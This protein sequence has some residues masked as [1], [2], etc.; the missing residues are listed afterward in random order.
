MEKKNIIY[1]AP[2]SVALEMHVDS[3]LAQSTPQD[4][5]LENFVIDEGVW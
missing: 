5:D 4:A 3:C 1:I 2:Q